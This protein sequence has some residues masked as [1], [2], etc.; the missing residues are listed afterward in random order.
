MDPNVTLLELRDAVK[1]LGELDLVGELEYDTQVAVQSVLDRFRDLDEWLTSKKG[2]PPRD[3]DRVPTVV[4]EL[5]AEL[6]EHPTW[7][8]PTRDQLEAAQRACAVRVLGGGESFD[9]QCVDRQ[10]GREPR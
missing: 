10:L 1:V 6:N 8:P 7:N 9:Q 4:A 5:E 2:F 3:W